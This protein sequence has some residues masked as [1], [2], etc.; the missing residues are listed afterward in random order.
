MT[1]KNLFNNN[2]FKMTKTLREALSEF[3]PLKENNHNLG[4]SMSDLIKSKSLWQRI[5]EL[6]EIE[7]SIKDFITELRRI[8]SD[9]SHQYGCNF[10]FV[11]NKKPNQLYVVVL[12]NDEELMGFTTDF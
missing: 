7:L 10:E 12:L 9:C 5:N 6:S 1:D 4:S 8:E 2:D 11:I 3:D